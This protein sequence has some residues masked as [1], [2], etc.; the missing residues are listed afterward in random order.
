MAKR[1]DIEILAPATGKVLPL[2]E[3]KDEVFSA[4][5]M[6]QGFGLEPSAE[7]EIEVVAPVSG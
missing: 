4:G 7:G 1:T 5:T 6:G 2:C 3:T